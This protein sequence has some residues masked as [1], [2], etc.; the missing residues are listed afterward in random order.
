[1]LSIIGL[2]LSITAIIVSIRTARLPYKKKIILSSSVLIEGSVVPGVSVESSIIG[3]AA[4]AINVGNRTVNLTYLGY[5]VKQ[6][7]RLNFYL[8]N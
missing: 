6:D 4:S 5:A 8:F 7:G 2:V 1:M 3:I